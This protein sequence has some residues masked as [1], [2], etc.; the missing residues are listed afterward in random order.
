ALLSTLLG[1]PPR[2][3]AVRRPDAPGTD[4]TTVLA[5][6]PDEERHAHVL[7]LVLDRTAQVLGHTRPDEVDPD[8]AFK[9]QGFDSLTAVELRNQLKAATGLDIPATL[10]FD[11]PSPTALA[12]HLLLRLLPAGPSPQ[13]RLRRDLDRLETTAEALPADDPAHAEVTERLRRILHLL[14]TPAAAPAGP[15]D[16]DEALRAA[17]A[18]E[19]LAFIDSEFGDLT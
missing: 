2:R 3:A 13:E 14:E 8:Q 1:P 4:L 5:A 9:D 7:A 18:D 17:T 6:L 19:V 16:G 11:H 15:A 12:D 10:V